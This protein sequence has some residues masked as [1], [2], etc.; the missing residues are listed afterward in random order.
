MTR[1]KRATFPLVFSIAKT[2]HCLLPRTFTHFVNTFLTSFQVANILSTTTTD[3]DRREIFSLEME[4]EFLELS[5][6]AAAA[7]LFPG[8]LKALTSGAGAVPYNIPSGEQLMPDTNKHV[9]TEQVVP[10]AKRI[11]GLQDGQYMGQAA[12]DREGAPM[13][14][15][16]RES[17]RQ[18]RALTEGYGASP[19]GQRNPFSRPA[20]AGPLALPFAKKSANSTPASTIKIEDERTELEQIDPSLL[21]LSQG[22]ELQGT[23]KGAKEH[24]PESPGV[25]E[26][27]KVAPIQNEQAEGM[28]EAQQPPTEG[29]Q[30]QGAQQQQPQPTGQSS[31]ANAI[32][33]AY[34]EMLQRI[35]DEVFR[36][37]VTE[38]LEE[39]LQRA[40][41][42]AALI[43]GSA[44]KILKKFQK[45]ADE[46]DEMG[47][48]EDFNCS[49]N[50]TA[51]ALLWILE[52]CALNVG[53]TP[54][55]AEVS[56]RVSRDALVGAL[57]GTVRIAD[58]IKW[59]DLV[60]FPL[61]F[62][63]DF[64]LCTLLWLFR[65]DLCVLQSSSL[66]RMV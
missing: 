14:G 39:Q 51:F 44:G 36:A 59:L 20:S 60:S 33:P 49:L 37:H 25:Q 57:W 46:C 28:M 38:S 23:A 53:G 11:K 27:I 1:L 65:T 9:P 32:K 7:G 15:S 61:F 2:I 66:S 41:A 24:Q 48:H 12:I 22:A 47:L 31:A 21:A 34:D 43:E 62:F 55:A 40:P 26:V 58:P 29:Q 6:R 64:S 56:R 16:S 42:V 17:S 5:K 35:E 50:N 30:E 13:P 54:L 45:A 10:P 8:L 4:G 19:V 52:S 18:P 3:A 63:V